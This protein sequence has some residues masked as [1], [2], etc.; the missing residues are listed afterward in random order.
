MFHI[1]SCGIDAWVFLCL[2]LLN[3]DFYLSLSLFWILMDFY[4]M[5][6]LLNSHVDKVIFKALTRQKLYY[7]NYISGIYCIC[8]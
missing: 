7:Q 5:M 8:S 6:I 3:C 2:R 1:N 4:V